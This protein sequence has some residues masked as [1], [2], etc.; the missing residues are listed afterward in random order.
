M[1][2]KKPRIRIYADENIPIPT[3]THLRGKGISIQH[4]Y[5]IN[6]INKSD[7]SHFKKSQS[8]K[9]I[10]L[11][12]DKDF[13]KFEGAPLKNHPG[14]IL[15]TTGNNTPRHINRILDKILKHITPEFI[16]HTLVRATIDKLIREKDEKLLIKNL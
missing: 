1:P 9:R 12:L 7:N 4:A 2:S 16:K 11:S 14:V 8:L 6:F 5:D 10:L 13:T 15:I 3:V